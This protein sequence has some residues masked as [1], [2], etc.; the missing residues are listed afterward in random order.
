[1]KPSTIK[2]A[3]K[4]LKKKEARKRRADYWEYQ[5]TCRDR[6]SNLLWEKMAEDESREIMK[7]LGENISET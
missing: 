1:V 2:K 7:R 4:S 5:R 3:K 6:F